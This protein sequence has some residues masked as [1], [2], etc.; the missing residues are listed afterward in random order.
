MPG[1]DG[2]DGL[3]NEFGVVERQ[4]DDRQSS[5]GLKQRD[6]QKC[7]LV[8]SDGLQLWVRLGWRLESCFGSKIGRVEG[9]MQ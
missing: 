8:E 5:L 4:A 3:E 2:A 9:Q 1:P 7:Y 6:I